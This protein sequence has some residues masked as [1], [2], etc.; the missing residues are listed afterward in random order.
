MLLILRL[1]ASDDIFAN[2]R[3][4]GRQEETAKSPQMT[5]REQAGSFV[6]DRVFVN[7]GFC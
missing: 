3:D 4:F 7:Q 2:H 1:L 5:G 6:C